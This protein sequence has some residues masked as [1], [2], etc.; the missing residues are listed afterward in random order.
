MAG[1]PLAR[2]MIA[3]SRLVGRWLLGLIGLGALLL[4]LAG[5]LVWSYQS[6]PPFA[7]DLGTDDDA[8]PF[9]SG[10]HQPEATPGGELT[11]RWTRASATVLV[12]AFGRRDAVLTLRL[13][14]AGRGDAPFPS[15]I[16]LAGGQEIAHLATTAAPQTYTVA[17]PA[18][19]MHGGDAADRAAHDD[20]PP[21]Q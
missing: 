9:I 3:P 16:V 19:L 12:P 20:L 18:A 11:F 10:F 6:A 14:G 7:L 4:A 21:A 1:S 8:E 2:T 13:A 5:G 17:V 15:V